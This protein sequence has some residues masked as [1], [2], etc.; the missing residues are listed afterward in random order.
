MS[1]PLNTPE[2]NEAWVQANIE[3]AALREQAWAQ[4]KS[5][6]EHEERRYQADLDQID[7]VYQLRTGGTS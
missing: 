2:Q 1:T 4:H 7:R 3:R 6:V 5:N